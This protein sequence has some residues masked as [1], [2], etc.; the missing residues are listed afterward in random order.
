MPVYTNFPTN[1]PGPTFPVERK[2]TPR[3]LKVEF[4]DGYTQESPDGLNYQLGEW[5][6]TWD[7]ILAA[8]KD[9]IRAFF[10]A[11]R[12]VET[13]NWTAPDGVVYKVKCRSWNVAI[14]AANSWR[15]TA[16]FKEAPI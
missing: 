4:G 14:V 6:L 10:E 7:N 13:F 2:L 11:R 9:T 12:G 3:I 1:V 16:E 8:E 15:I 5:S